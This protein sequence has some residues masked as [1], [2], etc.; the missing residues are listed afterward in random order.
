MLVHDRSFGHCRSC[1]FTTAGSQPPCRRPAPRLLQRT[2]IEQHLAEVVAMPLDVERMRVLR[3]IGDA[4]VLVGER[5]KRG[6]NDGFVASPS[7][8]AAL[9][10]A[11]HYL[12]G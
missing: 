9:R 12:A 5:A 7:H 1:I 11:A 4:L 8:P 2:V 3:R 6:S 10:V